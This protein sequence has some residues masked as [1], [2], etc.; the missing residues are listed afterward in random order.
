MKH[1]FNRYFSINGFTINQ[2]NLSQSIKTSIMRVWWK[3]PTLFV[4]R[5][6]KVRSGAW[7]ESHL[8][9]NTGAWPESH[10]LISMWI[11]VNKA[12]LISAY[13]QK[14]QRHPD[15]DYNMLG[16]LFAKLK[17]SSSWAFRKNIKAID[18]CWTSLKGSNFESREKKS[19]NLIL[20]SFSRYRRPSYRTFSV[21]LLLHGV[22]QYFTTVCYSMN[23]WYKMYKSW[24]ITS[25]VLHFQNMWKISF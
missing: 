14:L 12:D 10:L 8:K 24:F 1:C 21:L 5:T 16:T 6:I 4:A 22:L 11:L 7:T 18:A 20:F 17:W 13:C 3:I 9:V 15:I 2:I 19:K 25:F 23:A